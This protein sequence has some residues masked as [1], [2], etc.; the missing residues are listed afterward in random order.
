MAAAFEVAADNETIIRMG[1]NKDIKNI[2]T[3]NNGEFETLFYKK[4]QRLRKKDLVLGKSANVAGI[5]G[6]QKEAHLHVYYFHLST[7]AES[8]IEHLKRVELSDIQ[9]DGLNSWYPQSY[10]SFTPS[11]SL[12]QRNTAQRLKN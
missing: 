10:S 3:D 2:E 5:Q 7:T 6:I 11:I 12:N 1:D 4:N 9:C 8:L